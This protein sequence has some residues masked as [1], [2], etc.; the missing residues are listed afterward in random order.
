MSV[1]WIPAQTTTPPFATAR[2]AA[3]TSP[4]TGAK[5]MAASSSSG[6]CSFE[7]PAHAAPSP[8]ANRW[9]S[10]S[11]ALVNGYLDNYV[12]GG[13]ESVEAE[14]FGVVGHPQG[15]VAD[16]ARAQERRG[17]HVRV[18]LGDREAE[19]VVGRGIRGVAANDLVAGDQGQPRVRQLAVH[20]V[21]V[22]PAHRAGADPDQDLLRS[23]LRLRHLVGAQRLTRRVEDHGAH[24][25]NRPPAPR[26]RAGSRCG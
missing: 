21:Q 11:P 7:P 2:S 18:T 10:S 17:L 26:E 12:G 23:H 14:A 22:R 19:A 25:A 24:A 16:Q 3:G 5:M 1:M 9:P 6:G 4:P 15:A 8:R 20:D 13:A